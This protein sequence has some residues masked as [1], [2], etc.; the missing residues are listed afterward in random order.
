[1]NNSK[2]TPLN[3]DCI[4]SKD[5]LTKKYAWIIKTKNVKIYFLAAA[6]FTAAAFVVFVILFLVSNF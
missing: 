4:S 2:W 3:G 6:N 5:D 1:M